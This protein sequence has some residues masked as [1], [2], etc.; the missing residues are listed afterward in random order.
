MQAC[1]WI[2]TFRRNI[3]PTSSEFKCAIQFKFH[4]DVY[5]VSKRLLEMSFRNSFLPLYDIVFCNSKRETFPAFLVPLLLVLDLEALHCLC[6]GAHCMFR[7]TTHLS[8]H[9]STSD[10][11]CIASTSLE[12]MR[13]IPLET[14][15][16]VSF[17]PHNGPARFPAHSALC[18]ECEHSSLP[19]G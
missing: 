14:R 19:T 1:R 16:L 10:E 17:S 9:C 18:S 3:L 6:P 13:V 7:C 11:A 2:S 5:Y 12:T 4:G 15:H 8:V